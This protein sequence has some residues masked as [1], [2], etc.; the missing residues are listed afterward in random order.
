MDWLLINPIYKA[1]L[2]LQLV[3]LRFSIHS[4][5]PEIHRLKTLKLSEK[6]EGECLICYDDLEAGEK[7]AR[8]PC[9]CIYHVHC[10]DAWFKKKGI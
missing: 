1:L 3:V 7:I 8:L 10:I 9:L 4:L 5:E 2:W 6:N